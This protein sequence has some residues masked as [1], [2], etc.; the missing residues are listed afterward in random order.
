MS[1]AGQPPRRIWPWLIAVLSVAVMSLG[2][3]A[4]GAGGTKADQ[5][6]LR[7]I[8]ATGWSPPA[9]AGGPS[10]AN[11]C[12]D[13]K[14]EIGHL[15][16]FQQAAATKAIP[17]QAKQA[18]V[19][20]QDAVPKVVAE[21][22]ADIAAIAKAYLTQIGQLLAVVATSKNSS[23]SPKDLPSDVTAHPLTNKQIEGFSGYVSTNCHFELTNPN[24]AATP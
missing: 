24:T 14:A 21:A 16:Q 5:A 22:P 12:I 13:L 15:A 9:L 2:V 6:P 7:G 18:V 1:A 10:V 8:K 17:Y 3:V 20:F 11:L 23:K 19:D 4:C